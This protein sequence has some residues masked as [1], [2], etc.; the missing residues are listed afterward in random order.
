M[1]KI[2]PLFLLSTLVLLV[3]CS[4]K[5]EEKQSSLTDQEAIAIGKNLYE[6]AIELIK[7]QK[8]LE[9]KAVGWVNGSC[10]SNDTDSCYHIITNFDSYVDTIFTAERKTQ[11]EK[12][13]ENIVRSGNTVKYVKNVAYPGNIMAIEGYDIDL[14]KNETNKIEFNII[15][16]ECLNN[17]YV[18]TGECEDKDIKTIKDDYVIV[19]QQGKWVIDKF[20]FNR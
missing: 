2:L 10:P 13:E 15:T 4:T 1:K 3:G 6:Q 12:E 9:M 5:Q 19:K 20:K 17:D 14:V 7:E 11:Y 16:K 18:I 8:G